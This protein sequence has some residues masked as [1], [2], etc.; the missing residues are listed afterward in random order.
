MDSISV[1]FYLKDAAKLGRKKY[2]YGRLIINGKK[3]EFATGFSIE[4]RD[5]DLLKQSPKN[6]ITIKQELIDIENNIYRIRRSFIDNNA[7]YSTKDIINVL[8]NKGDTRNSTDLIDFYKKEL[9]EMIDKDESAKSTIRHYQGTLKILIAF[10]EYSNIDEIRLQGLSYSFIKDLD[11]YMSAVYLSP[12][13]KKI[14]RNTINKHHARIKAIINF[15]LKERIVDHNPYAQYKFKYE[16]TRREHLSEEELEK[17]LELDLS[18]N[19]S[20]NKVRDIFI[21]S[22]NTGIRFQDAQD[23]SMADI[24]HHPKN[25]DYLEFQM[26]K[27]SEVIALPLLPMTKEVIKKYND[28]DDDDRA[29]QEKILPQISNQK[30]NVYIK[31]IATLANIDKKLSHHIA[32]HTF[33]TIALNKGISIVTVQKLLGHTTVRTTEIYAKLLQDTIF[34]EMEKMG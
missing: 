18:N 12:Y 33:A 16:K 10:K 2:I 3:S 6:N 17:I 21:F 19:N 4:S 22:C 11:Y 30:F 5:W 27:T 7:R 31:H 13:D 14:M 15:A 32:R 28:N 34:K 25:G 26:T 20:L 24:K 1:K 9:Q 8:K 23:L 29:V